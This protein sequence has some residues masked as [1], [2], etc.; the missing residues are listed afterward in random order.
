MSN[1]MFSPSTNLR[2]APRPTEKT[3][4]LRKN[5][6]CQPVRFA[7]FNLRIVRMVIKGHH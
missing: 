7:V 4:R 6:P 3:F 5:L 2:N 1:E